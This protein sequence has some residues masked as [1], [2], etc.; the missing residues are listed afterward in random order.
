MI[1]Q[2]LFIVGQFIIASLEDKSKV[3]LI[4]KK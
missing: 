4:T 1:L 3:L 2:R